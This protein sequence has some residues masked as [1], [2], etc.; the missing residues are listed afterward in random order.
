VADAVIEAHFTEHGWPP[1]L[2]ELQK[3]YRTQSC[4]TFKPV[5]LIL[6][7]MNTFWVGLVGPRKTW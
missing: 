3:A 2:V 1:E 4:P 6:M 5:E 7:T